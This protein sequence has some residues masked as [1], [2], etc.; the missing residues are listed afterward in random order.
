LTPFTA[1]GLV[2]VVALIAAN[3][4]FVAVEFSFVAARRSRFVELAVEGDRRSRRAIDV[5][6]RLSFMLSGAQLGITVT[7]VVLGFIAEPAIAAVIEPVLEAAGVPE[8]ATFGIALVIALVLATMAQMVFGELAPKNLA[9][10][11]PEPV[12]RRLAPSTWLFIRIAGPVIRLFDGAANRL[13]RLLGV[14]P[15]EEL[16]GAVSTEELDLI[17]DSSA[18]SGHLTVLQAALLERAIDFGELEASDAMVPWNRV[19]TVAAAATAADLRDLM[20]STHSRFP[21]VD[22]DDQVLGI[23]HAKDLLGV[24]RDAYDTTAVA[25]MLREVLAVPEAAGLNVVLAELR[26]HSTEM[27]IVIDEYGGPAGV[28]TLEDIVEELVGDIEDEYDPSAPGEHVEV[29]PG[30]WSVA[31][32]SRPDEIE[33]VTGLDLPDGEY[34]TVAGLVLEELE[35]IPEV[36]ESFVVDGVVVQVLEV[37]GFAIQRLQ[38][39]VDPEALAAADTDGGEDEST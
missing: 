13:L 26:E 2:G 22:T 30:V 31:A 14:E 15:V 19:V 28:V 1:L 5:H 37:D 34:D 25:S 21:V 9:I 27:A 4:Y 38:L 10:A 23:V 12:A 39:R 7:T 33:R 18:E 24:G 6:R 20:S 8:S 32:T 35:H 17:V 11:R 36:G 29:E 3:G 16:R